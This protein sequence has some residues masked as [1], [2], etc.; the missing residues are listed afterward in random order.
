MNPEQEEKLGTVKISEDVISLCVLDSAR[1]VEGFN[2]FMRKGI[3][4]NQTEEGLMLDLYITV[5]Y[6]V[7]IPEIA[8]NIQERVK[9][10]VESVIDQPVKKV[11]IHVQGVHFPEEVADEQK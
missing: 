8:W 2:G 3:R 11:N 7:K 5:E 10:D 9:K 4:I 1:K 6:G